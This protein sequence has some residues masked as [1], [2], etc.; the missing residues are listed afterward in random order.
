MRSKLDRLSPLR[1][2]LFLALGGFIC[3]SFMVGC[4]K[5]IDSSRVPSVRD[6]TNGFLRATGYGH[7]DPNIGVVERRFKALQEAKRDAYAQLS[8]EVY[9]L[10][11]NA[12]KHVADL[13]SSKREMEEK[14]DRFVQ[15]AKVVET[16]F[17]TDQQIE[18]DMELYLGASL[19]SLL[20]LLEKPPV[21]K[22]S[23]SR[24][25]GTGYEP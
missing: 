16:R 12:K 2:L 10:P 22:S 23:H 8:H 19:R 20:G 7:L 3:L 24:P 17:V 13:V 6:W 21:S 15:S 4:S 14:I 9:A 25:G 11:V 1:S 5:R 18:V